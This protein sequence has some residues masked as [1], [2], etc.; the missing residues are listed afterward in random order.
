MDTQPK[1]VINYLTVALLVVLAASMFAQ[2]L[3]TAAVLI[4]YSDFK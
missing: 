2:G 1:S 4:D 3:K